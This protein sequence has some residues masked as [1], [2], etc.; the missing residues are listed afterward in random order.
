MSIHRLKRYAF[1]TPC[2][3][4]GEECKGHLEVDHHQLTDGETVRW[5]AVR[6]KKE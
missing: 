6:E 3:M 5:I 2:P 1:I 4:C